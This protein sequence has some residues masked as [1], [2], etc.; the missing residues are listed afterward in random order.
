[1][2]IGWRSSAHS[3]EDPIRQFCSSRKGSTHNTVATGVFLSP[4]HLHHNSGND[5]GESGFK[6]NNGG[7][8]KMLFLVLGWL[9]LEWNE[10]F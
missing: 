10:A 1:M 2:V 5:T 4:S 8:D 9:T 3:H 7:I 6:F